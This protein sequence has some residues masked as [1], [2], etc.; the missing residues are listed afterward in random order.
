MAVHFPIAL[1][2]VAFLFEVKSYFYKKDFFFNQP[3]TYSY[4]VCWVP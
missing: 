2:M 3:F 1:L 4:Q